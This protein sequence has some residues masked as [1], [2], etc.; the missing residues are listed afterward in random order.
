MSL[1]DL[2]LVHGGEHAADCW[3]LTVAELRRLSPELRIL[4]VDLPGHGAKPGNLATATIAEWVD[5]VI[6][7]IEEA[8]LGTSSLSVIRWP[9]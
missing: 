3:D 9:G 8:R 1:P 6:A 5:S 4:A 7:D 2:V